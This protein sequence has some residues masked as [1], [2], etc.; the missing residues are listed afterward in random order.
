MKAPATLSVA[1]ISVAATL[2]LN[3]LSTNAMEPLAVTNSAESD[4]ISR[5]GYRSQNGPYRGGTGRRE[6]LSQGNPE[7]LFG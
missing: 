5:G 4:V 2:G 3:A 6:I 7:I 1:L